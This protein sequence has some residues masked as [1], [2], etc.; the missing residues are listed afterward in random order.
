MPNVPKGELGRLAEGVTGGVALNYGG[1]RSANP[2][3]PMKLFNPA[4][5]A[6]NAKQSSAAAPF[7][8]ASSLRSSQ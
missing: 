3:Y 8:I 5:I 1:L 7:W 2:R 6:S 4:V